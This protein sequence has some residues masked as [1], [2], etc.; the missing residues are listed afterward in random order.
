MVNNPQV[1]T[2]GE[3]RVWRVE[4]KSSRR[5]NYKHSVGTLRRL[6]GPKTRQQH[7]VG[8]EADL[9]A[10]KEGARG[11]TTLSSPLRCAGVA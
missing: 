7:V 2:T 4:R 11:S 3:H 6:H 9:E 1:S 8:A 10:M 5:G